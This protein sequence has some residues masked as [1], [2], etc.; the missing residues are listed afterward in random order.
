MEDPPRLLVNNLIN[1]N[2]HTVYRCLQNMLKEERARDEKD[3][4]SLGKKCQNSKEH[5]NDKDDYN[6]N[7]AE[8]I[9]WVSSSVVALFF[10]NQSSL[11]RQVF[12]FKIC[13]IIK[14]RWFHKFRKLIINIK[15]LIWKETIWCR[16]QN[17]LLL[18]M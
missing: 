4:G 11:S 3:A 18:A 14:Y 10:S 15:C 16:L 9:R 13:I 7:K 8:C 17:S 12:D 1:N 2:N 5:H 6:D